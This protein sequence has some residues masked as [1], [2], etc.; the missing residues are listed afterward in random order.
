MKAEIITIGDEILIGQIIDTNSSWLGQELGKM[1]ISV[2]HRA[3]VSD[4]QLHIKQALND[5]TKRADIIIMTGGLGPTK[6][7][8]TKHTLANYFGS[9]LIL[10]DEVLEWVSKIFRMRKLPM[11]DSNRNQ[12][13]VPANCDVLFNSSGTAPGM[14][15]DVDGKIFISMPGVPFEMKAIFEEHCVM[16]L[17]KRF[18]LPAII[19]RTIQTCSIGESF[20]AKKIEDLE[21]NLPKHIKLAYLPNVGQV[22]LRFSGYHS[23]QEILKAEMDTII[24]N[25]YE[26]IGEY[27]FGEEDDSLQKVVGILLK[28]KEKT[29]ATAESCTGG[30]L[31]HLITS[32]PG[33]SNYYQGSVIS[34]ANEIKINELNVSPETLKT[35]GAVSEDCVKQMAEGV[36]KKLNTDYA[37]STSG[38]AG[39]DGGSAEKPIGTVWIAVSSK[40]QTIAQQ[41]NMG[42]NRERTIHRTALQGLD[43]LRKML[44]EE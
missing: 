32:V 34:Y 36:R 16:R 24:A 6:D 1:G 4:Q 20:L 27:I 40:T 15:F 3:S 22:R 25:L 33:S 28:G 5:A 7:D 35:V 29:L 42:D 8:V 9:E 23:N 10:N 31:A 21:N 11:I 19:H 26:R 37:I 38:I 30:Y 18:N 13:M 43:M 2:V 44:L 12:A 41:F 17:Q 39:P 14:W